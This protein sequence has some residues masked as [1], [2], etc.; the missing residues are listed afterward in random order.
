[1]Y[2]CFLWVRNFVRGRFLPVVVLVA[3][4]D[5]FHNTQKIPAVFGYFLPSLSTLEVPDLSVNIGMCFM[6]FLGSIVL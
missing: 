5:H 3:M 2:L 1:M 6:C 4:G